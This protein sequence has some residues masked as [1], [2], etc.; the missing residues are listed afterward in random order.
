MHP[1]ASHAHTF[2]ALSISKQLCGRGQPNQT[3]YGIRIN[4]HYVH[5]VYVDIDHKLKRKNPNNT[6][7]LKPR[8]IRH[9]HTAQWLYIRCGFLCFR[10][11]LKILHNTNQQHFQLLERR[12]ECAVIWIHAP[13]NY[14]LFKATQQNRKRS[15][16]AY[17]TSQRTL[18]L[19]GFYGLTHCRFIFNG[20]QCQRD[21]LS[22]LYSTY[23][24]GQ[25]VMV[26]KCDFV[27]ADAYFDCCEVIYTKT[28]IEIPMRIKKKWL[29]CP[30]SSTQ[31]S[32]V[33]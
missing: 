4:K 32:E 22:S 12:N 20:F 25:S 33:K 23:K 29:K 21:C 13:V 27:W 19:Y 15:R 1:K 5:F 2:L 10:P 8:L 11:P 18:N 26:M 9:I 30:P 6:S 16:T 28:S 7:T 24:L 3:S 31:T 14:F 17:T